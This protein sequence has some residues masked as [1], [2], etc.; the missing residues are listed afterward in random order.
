[1]CSNA[2]VKI[3]LPVCGAKSADHFSLGL[4]IMLNHHAGSGC[5]HLKI[6]SLIDLPVEAQ[7]SLWARQAAALQP[8]ACEVHPYKEKAC[9]AQQ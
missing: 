6:L 8:V 9:S 3:L 5:L 1:M 2:L 4:I 7:L